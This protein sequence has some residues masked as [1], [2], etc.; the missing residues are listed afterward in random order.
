MYYFLQ[1]L[2]LEA[3]DSGTGVPTLNR[4]H[5]DGLRVSIPSRPIQ[6]KIAAILS[7]YD[8]LIEN[9]LRRIEILEEMARNL[10]HEWF[11][12]FRFPGH[13]KA[14]FVDSPLGQIPEA[15]QVVRL[16]SLLS[17]H[18]GGG[19]GKERRDPEHTERAWVVRGTDLRAARHGDF[20]RVPLRWHTERNLATRRLTPGDVVLEVSGGSK[21]QRLGRCLQVTE[22]WLGPFGGEAVIC[23]SFCKRVRAATERIAPELLFFGLLDARASGQMSAYEVQSTGISNLQWKRFIEGTRWYLPPRHLQSRFC[24]VVEALRQE[25][26]ILGQRNSTL[27]TVRDLLLPKLVSGEIDVSEL[28][29]RTGPVVA[30][31]PSSRN[32]IARYDFF[33]DIVALPFVDKIALFGSRARGDQM[34]HSDIDLAVFCDGA[35]D[36]DWL[37]VLDCLREDRV[38]TLLKV[39]CVRFDRCDAVLQEHV[40]TEGVVLY[41]KDC[42]P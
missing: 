34:E 10:Y 30:R 35:S 17:G 3:F 37:E 38:D 16:N 21:G 40:L 25:V 15:W 5:L 28:S 4:N 31:G 11:V 9:S 26:A 19:W 14:R 2:G 33:Q 32:D 18:I 1:T 23:A 27:R 22:E 6:E 41:E 7:A 42:A 36:E 39:D 12:R 24:E 13:E 20:T 29:V 8:D